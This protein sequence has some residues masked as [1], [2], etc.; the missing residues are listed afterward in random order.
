MEAVYDS[1]IL[2]VF[3][4]TLDNGKRDKISPIYHVLEATFFPQT[5]KQKAH[6]LDTPTAISDSFFLTYKKDYAPPCP[7][8]CCHHHVLQ[9]SPRLAP[10]KYPCYEGIGQLIHTRDC[11]SWLLTSGS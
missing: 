8:H 5:L 10:C 7:G 4:G 2:S 3:Q 11:A 9:A 6:H 1:I